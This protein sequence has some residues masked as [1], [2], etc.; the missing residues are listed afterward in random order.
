MKKGRQDGM[1]TVEA[2]LSLVPFIMAILGIISFINIFAVHNKIQYSMY[3]MANELSC[4]T[5]FYQAL[6]LRDADK[7][8]GED[9][10]KHTEQLDSAI[11]ELNTFIEQIGEMQ[12]SDAGHLVETGAELLRDPKALLRGFVYLGVEKA[13]HAAKSFLLEII[14]GGLM[15]VYLDESFLDT[16][17]RKAD[18]YLKAFGVKD[19]IDG[20]DFGKSELFS[21]EEYRMIDIVVEYDLEV[22]ILK[23]FLKDPTIHVVQRCAVPA[24][25]DGDGTSY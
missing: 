25:L 3:Q 4:Y 14:S 5:Y 12:G 11:E 16:R 6:G 2:V 10:D 13:E 15:E 7:Q 9:A 19:G 24:W 20:L 18:E 23:L 17:P 22:Y 8:L 21:D 1:L